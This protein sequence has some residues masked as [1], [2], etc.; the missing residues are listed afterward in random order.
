MRILVVPIQWF[1]SRFYNFRF[2]FVS[3]DIVASRAY[4][5]IMIER[6]IETENYIP[7]YSNDHLL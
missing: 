3:I 6:H 4:S 2:V 7:E 5:F 1:L